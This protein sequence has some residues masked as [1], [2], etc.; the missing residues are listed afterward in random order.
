MY[1][2]SKKDNPPKMTFVNASGKFDNTIHRM[3]YGYWEELNSTIQAEPL[4]GLD[5]DTRGLL[6]SI[7]IRKGVEFKP[8]A[9]MKKILTDAEAI[10]SVT[11]RAL[12]ARPSDQRHYLYPGKRVWTNPFVQG[13]YDFLLDGER[14]LD[15][16][17]YMHFYAT[18]IT[19]AMA[20][21]N[22]GNGS[23][24]AIA[25]LDKDGNALDGSNTYK[26]NLPKNVPAKDFWSFTLYD[27]QTRGMLQTDQRF[28]GV[29]QNKKGLKQNADGSY[30]VYFGPK[31]PEGQENNWIQ[32]DP[33]KGWNT[34]LRLYG[35]LEPFYDKTWIPGDPELVEDGYD[36]DGRRRPIRDALK[37]LRGN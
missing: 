32:T 1:P 15:S 4:E 16:R 3:D 31:A 8:D 10:G 7:G 25:Y 13:R 20:I 2:L 27:N 5:P 21:K 18:G 29:D 30:D 37:N 26:I 35:P 24:Y 22:V 33:S 12:T 14:L 6:A 19:P 17:I 11:S 9:R 36:P 34:I 28:P 23:Q